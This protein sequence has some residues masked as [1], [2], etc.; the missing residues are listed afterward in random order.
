MSIDFFFKQDDGESIT[1]EFL[2]KNLQVDYDVV[3]IQTNDDNIVTY[4]SVNPKDKEK[5][6]YEE[7]Y[8]FVLQDDN[9]YWH[10]ILSRDDD[11]FGI[12]NAVINDIALAL[13]LELDFN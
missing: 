7:G 11:E 12:E 8:E 10:E 9:R 6:V 13:H 2:L 5:I 4:F 1:K 3:K